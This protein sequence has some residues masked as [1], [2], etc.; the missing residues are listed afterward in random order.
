MPYP[1]T[2][3]LSGSKPAGGGTTTASFEVNTFSSP[4]ILFPDYPSIEVEDSASII[5]NELISKG[6]ITS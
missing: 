6:V 5:I 1:Y 4:G 2:L 3:N